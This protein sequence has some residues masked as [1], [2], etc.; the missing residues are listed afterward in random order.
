MRASD[1]ALGLTIRRLC[2]AAPSRELPQQSGFVF[3]IWVAVR[4]KHVMK[5]DWRWSENIGSLPGIPWKVS[6]RLAGDKSPI[7]CCHMV[8]FRDRQDGIECASDRAGHVL[9]A[10]DRTSVGFQPFDSLFEVFRPPIMVK[11]DDV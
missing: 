3:P 10:D 7:N 8:S 2:L 11:G 1:L 6:L 9:G 5:P 4:M